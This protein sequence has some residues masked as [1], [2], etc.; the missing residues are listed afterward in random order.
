M[1]VVKA[2]AALL[3]NLNPNNVNTPVLGPIRRFNRGVFGDQP[4]S[5]LLR[6]EGSRGDLTNLALSVGAATPKNV[7]IGGKLLQGLSPED[8]ANW[9]RYSNWKKVPL[10]AIELAKR[11]YTKDPFGKFTGSK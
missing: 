1:D 9:V 10:T 2:A 8:Y 6:G 7:S 5:R 11:K 4:A 3:G